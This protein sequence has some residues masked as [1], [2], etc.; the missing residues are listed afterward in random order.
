MINWLKFSLIFFFKK[1]VRIR[2]SN[3]IVKN[4]FRFVAM[5]L[6]HILHNNGS[7]KA[8]IVSPK[9][10]HD[11]IGLYFGYR[12]SPSSPIKSF[13]W[14]RLLHSNGGLFILLVF[15]LSFMNTKHSVSD[16]SMYTLGIKQ[17]AS[18]SNLFNVACYWILV[19]NAEFPSW[20]KIWTKQLSVTSCSCNSSKYNCQP[21]VTGKWCKG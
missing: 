21:T 7:R 3:G 8:K 17:F 5:F 15:F 11:N 9:C 1:I 4:I 16:N 13:L 19:W 6:F 20:L 2:V 14:L 18:C 12:E 10:I